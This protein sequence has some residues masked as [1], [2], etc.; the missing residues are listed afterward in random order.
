M[1]SD[2]LPLQGCFGKQP[3][4][5]TYLIAFTGGAIRRW[6]R[7]QKKYVARIL[8]WDFLTGVFPITNSWLY[9]QMNTKLRSNDILNCPY[10][11]VR[12]Y[13][14]Y[15]CISDLMSLEFNRYLNFKPFFQNRLALKSNLGCPLFFTLLA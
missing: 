15:L 7:I 1:C 13:I 2:W 4:Q 14:Y 8:F 10:T 6:G 12:H 9:I 11:E 5:C 3:M